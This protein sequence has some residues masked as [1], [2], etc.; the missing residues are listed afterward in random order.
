MKRK[1]SALLAVLLIL[2]L[3]PVMASAANSA[4]G[5]WVYTVENGEATILWSTG[6][7]GLVEMFPAVLGGS[8]VTTIGNGTVNVSTNNKTSGNFVL[9]PQGVKLFNTMAIYDYNDTAGWSFPADIQFGENATKSIYGTFYCASGSPAEAYAKEIGLEV[10]NVQGTDFVASFSDGGYM[11]PNGQY[12]L[13]EAMLGGGYSISFTVK[14]DIGF[15]I[16]SLTVDG[17]AKEDAVGKTD[18]TFVYNFSQASSSVKVEFEAFEG[19]TRTP[20]DVVEYVAPTLAEGAVAEDAVLQDDVYTYCEVHDGTTAKYT[21]TMGISTGHYYAADGKIYSMVKSYQ[22]TEGEP[23]FWSVAEVINTAFKDEGLVYGKDYDLVRLYNYHELITRGPGGG[24]DTYM[25]A[26]YLY[27]EITLADVKDYDV[28]STHTNTAAIFVQKGGNITVDNFTTFTNTAGKGPSEA[29]NFFGMGSQIHGDGGDG[30]TA[31]TGNILVKSAGSYL[32]LNSPKVLGKSNS[33][34]ATAHS[35]INVNGGDIFSYTSGG[36]GPYV[37]TGGQVT[38]N[39]DGTAI[40][41]EDGVIDRTGNKALATDIPDYNLSAMARSEVTGEVEM[42]LSEHADDVTCIVT[43]LDAGTALATDSGGG[44]IVANKCVTK[45]YGLRSAGVYSIG[46]N[47]SWVYC[48]NSSLT[49]M[50]DAAL[51]SASGGYM[52]A[53]NCDLQGFQAIKT[54]AGQNGQT[55]S[56]VRVQ[57]SRAIA[58]YDYD[59]MVSAYDIADP[60][61]FDRSVLAD[62][63]TMMPSQGG[64]GESTIFIDAA[65]NSFY[66]DSLWWWFVDRSKTPGQSGGSNFAVIY[67]DSSPTPVYVDSTY[68]YNKN[69]EM[70]GPESQWWKEHEGKVDELTGHAYA[71]ANNLIA[72]SENG[73]TQNIV[74]INENSQTKW[75]VTG[76]NQETCEIVGDLYVA[77][78]VTSDAPGSGSGPSTMNCTFQ[79][80]EWEGT[81]LEYGYNCNLTFDAKSSWKV[82]ADCTVGTINLEEGTVIDADK[83]VT[84][85]FSKSN[86]VKDG[87]KM[88]NVTFVKYYSK[89]FS[90]VFESVDEIDYLADNDIVYGWGDGTFLPGQVMDGQHFALMLKRAGAKKVTFDLSGALTVD[91]A[92]EAMYKAASALKIT[93]K[94]ED[95]V[96]ALTEWGVYDASLKGQ[97]TRE[98]AAVLLYKFLQNKPKGMGM[99]MMGMG[100]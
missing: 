100:H 56:E 89:H 65:N 24:G 6:G 83:P 54:R 23:D 68:L 81:V 2:A 46:S 10:S 11:L 67:G 62:L 69:Y 82:T 3:C 25:Y 85:Y 8:P 13:P 5:N 7:K 27:K 95:M 1:L 12:S 26:A 21:N 43:G 59:G 30:T 75:D 29:G 19:D 93:S 77:E 51:C 17:A 92:Y 41:G 76:K 15:K 35:L 39:T 36:H 60:K 96:G 86:T 91:Q 16:K 14:S 55:E 28:D 78:I 66:E 72:S 48:Y 53:Y 22:K 33:I 42:V 52:Y 50:L 45:T 70:F 32:T 9:I 98:Q 79:N 73:G 64:S 71:P 90:D 20:E 74:F 38:I 57:N 63:A 37:S 61:D 31:T 94:S 87:D 84:V 4:Q 44:T 58:Y 40:V 99:M 80:S 47:E 34:Y 88:G 49:S 97:L 18:Y